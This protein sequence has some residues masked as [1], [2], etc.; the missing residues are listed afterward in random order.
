[1]KN[2][3]VSVEWLKNNL[4]KDE[5]VILDSSPEST[6]TGKASLVSDLSIPNTRIFNIKGD[7]TDKESKFPNTVPLAAQF[8][9]ACQS[10]GINADSEIVVYDNLGIYTSPRVWWLFKIMGHDNVRV[11]NGGLPEW[12]NQ[13]YETVKKSALKQDYKIGNFKSKFEEKYVINYR[14]IIDNIE[15]KKFLV[16]DARSKGRFDG[17]APEPRKY[18]K[19]GNIPDSINIPYKSLLENGKF[20]SE[21]ELNN[22]FNEQTN[23]QTDLVF[24]CGSGMTACIVM[25]A[26]EIAFKNSKYLYDGS[27]TEYA[28]LGNLRTDAPHS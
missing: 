16:V 18:L 22:I 15:T 19:S 7:F 6:I 12:V 24:S 2:N 17:T 20:K 26:S 8:E 10:L 25:L 9:E 3:I 21:Q 27:W 11:L 4:A 5:L 23:G 28:E 14:D 13:G 1:M